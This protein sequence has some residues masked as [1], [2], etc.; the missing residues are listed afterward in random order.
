MKALGFQPV[1]SASL[2]KLWFSSVNLHPYNAAGALDIPRGEIAMP[3]AHAMA[4]V[5]VERWAAT[6]CEAPVRSV[7]VEQH[8]GVDDDAA[9]V[10]KAEEEEDEG[11]TT[12]TANFVVAEVGRCRLTSG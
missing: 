3:G 1:E 6:E 12:F 10:G 5:L 7:H 4:R 11:G 9:A 2:S 8:E